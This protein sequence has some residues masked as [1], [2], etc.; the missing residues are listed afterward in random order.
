MTHIS[1]TEFLPA[2]YAAFQAAMTEQKI[3]G[4]FLKE[5]GLFL[6]TWKVWSRSPICSY[7]LQHL[8]R[9]RLARANL[10]LQRRQ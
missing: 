9:R 6:V 1:K 7:R 10:G 4:C 3:K 2:F 5:P 8:L